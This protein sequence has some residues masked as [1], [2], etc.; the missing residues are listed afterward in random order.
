MNKWHQSLI[1]RL[2][3]LWDATDFYKFSTLARL[4]VSTKIIFSVSLSRGC[5]PCGI[6]DTTMLKKH[7]AC[8]KD[9][10]ILTVIRAVRTLTQRTI[11][12]FRQYAYF[13]NVDSSRPI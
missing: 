3:T 5:P 7:L 11:S 10:T 1:F 13:C 6:K 9:T 12:E 2:V 4:K 8:I